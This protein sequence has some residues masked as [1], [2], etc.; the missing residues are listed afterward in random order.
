MKRVTLSSERHGRC[1]ARRRMD[2]RRIHW[3][4]KVPLSQAATRPAFI[5]RTAAACPGF[6]ID[7]FVAFNQPLPKFLPGCSVDQ[8]EISVAIKQ[9]R[10]WRWLLLPAS[11]GLAAQERAGA[12][13]LR[14]GRR[15]GYL[16]ARSGRIA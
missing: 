4:L 9:V 13:S 16:L 5:S 10:R 6:E 2:W 1:D 14:P 15:T 12:N 7:N 11:R 3:W 8:Y